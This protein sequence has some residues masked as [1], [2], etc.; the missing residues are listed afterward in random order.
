MQ[1]SLIVGACPVARFVA[2]PR[3]PPCCQ[4]HA[5][6]ARPAQARPFKARA[7]SSVFKTELEGSI[8][9]G[10]DSESEYCLPACVEGTGLLAGMCLEYGQAPSSHSDPCRAHPFQIR[11][12]GQRARG[13]L[14][15]AGCGGQ[16]LPRQGDGMRRGCSVRGAMQFQ[17]PGAWPWIII[18]DRASRAATSSYR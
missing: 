17:M 13:W 1:C 9:D 11:D 7:T 3:A 14:H 6:W 5:P 18:R 15:G 8:S 12:R 16:G 4:L 10:E 2:R